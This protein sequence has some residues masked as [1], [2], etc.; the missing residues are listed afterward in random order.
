MKLVGANYI[1]GGD[2]IDDRDGATILRERLT[3]NIGTLYHDIHEEVTQAFEDLV[4][5]KEDGE[6]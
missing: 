2:V 4:P 5:A 6:S 3:R 1:F